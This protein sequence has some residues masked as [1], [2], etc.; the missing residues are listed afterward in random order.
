MVVAGVI[1]LLEYCFVLGVMFPITV[2]L[3][4]ITLG[5]KAIDFKYAMRQGF[6][7]QNNARPSL[8]YLILSLLLG[9]ALLVWVYMSNDLHGRILVIVGV[10]FG[11]LAAWVFEAYYP[12]SRAPWRWIVYDDELPQG[13]SFFDP[14]VVTDGGISDSNTLDISRS[15]SQDVQELGDGVT[16]TMGDMGAGTALE[17]ATEVSNTSNSIDISPEVVAARE[18]DLEE[19][20]DKIPATDAVSEEDDVMPQLDPEVLERRVRAFAERWSVDD[21]PDNETVVEMQEDESFTLEGWLR[22]D[23][24]RRSAR[25]KVVFI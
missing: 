17:E 22:S 23:E 18:V 6:K 2:P 21:G 3:T 8:R 10:P 19:D 13:I 1:V 20:H 25:E 24:T 15:V 11:W 14:N 4:A 12:V 9:Y 7:P 5:C 16:I